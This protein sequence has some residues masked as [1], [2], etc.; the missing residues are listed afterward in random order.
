MRW[1]LLPARRALRCRPGAGR[2]RHQVTAAQYERW[3]TELSNWGRWGRGRSD[4]DPQP[5]HAGE[6]RAQA[7]A[8]R[9][10]RCVSVSL[11]RRRRHREGRG[12]PTRP[13]S[14]R[15]S[16]I[17]SDRIGI[18]Y[19]GI[20]HTISTRGTTFNANGV[21]YNEL[22]ART[23]RP[24][25]GRATSATRSSTSKNGIF[26]RGI[27]IEHPAPERRAVLE[28]GHAHLRRRI[29]KPGKSSAG[30]DACRPATR[31]SSAPASGRGGRRMGRGCADAGRG[32][33]VRRPRPL[34]HPVAPRARDVGGDG[35]RPSA[36]ASPGARPASARARFTTLR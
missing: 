8:L 7:A 20:A 25:P 12:Q 19:H 2:A 35:E 32:R 13:T 4:R 6:A 30:R 10:R 28:S 16:G 27:L 18:A 5:D 1:R 36:H 29:S 14:T 34:G 3:K 9:A 15:C 31:C 21:F 17:G 33:P 26:T 23:R 22:H 24:W 11:G